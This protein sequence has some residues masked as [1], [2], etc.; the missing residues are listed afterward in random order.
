[1]SHTSLAMLK[2]ETAVAAREKPGL[3]DF[4]CSYLLHDSLTTLSKHSLS[5]LTTKPHQFFTSLSQQHSF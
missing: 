3:G 5:S 1:M 4:S 2:S